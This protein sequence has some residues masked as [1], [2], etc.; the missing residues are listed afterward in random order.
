MEYADTLRNR[1]RICIERKVIQITLVE[2]IIK[3]EE[4]KL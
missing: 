3:I 2:K 1:R 4:D